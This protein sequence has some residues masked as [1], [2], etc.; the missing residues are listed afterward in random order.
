MI[1]RCALVCLDPIPGRTSVGVASHSLHMQGEAI[2][3][4]IPG[5]TMA[6]LR[7]AALSLHRGGVGY[8]PD[9]RFVHEDVGRVRRW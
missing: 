9:S 8:Y 5:V 4:R 2:D 1:Y 3:I 7:D 6:A